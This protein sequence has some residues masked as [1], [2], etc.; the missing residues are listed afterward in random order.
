MHLAARRT[1]LTPSIK[2]FIEARLSKLTEFVNNIVW[3]QVILGVEK[4][5]HHAEV[6]AHAGHQTMKAA[7]ESDDLYAAID[8]AMT[9]ME[10]Q[11][12]TITVLVYPMDQTQ[13]LVWEVFMKV[14]RALKI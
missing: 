3:V 2:G 8:K 13:E 7:A 6:V 1:K 10:S 5:I 11:I 9:K 14:I 4:K 12:R